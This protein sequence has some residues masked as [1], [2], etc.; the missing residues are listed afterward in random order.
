M[1]FYQFERTRPADLLATNIVMSLMTIERKI[2]A[3]IFPFQ[4]FDNGIIEQSSVRIHR[5]AQATF[6]LAKPFTHK[7]LGKIHAPADGV[8]TK[9]RFAAKESDIQKTLA[10]LQGSFK[11]EPN[12]RLH[13]VIRHHQAAHLV[14]YLVIAVGAT[15]VAPF[16]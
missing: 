10:K 7:I 12:C 1:R 13:N 5:K 8:H 2:D 9:Q 16:R 15:Q 14:A 6:A 3:E 4:E 11:S